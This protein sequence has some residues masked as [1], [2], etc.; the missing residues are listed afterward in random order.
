VLFGNPEAPYWR[1]DPYFMDQL[2]DDKGAQEALDAL[3]EAVDAN[4]WD[5]TLQ[6][7]DFCFMDNFRAVH[8]RRPFKARYDGTDRWLKR[9]NI[10]TDLR[11]SRSARSTGTARII[12]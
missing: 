6:P 3:I 4:I 10:T 8:G 9:I 12:F 2:K 5:L 7:G 1:L 11:K